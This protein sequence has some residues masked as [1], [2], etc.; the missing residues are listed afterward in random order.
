MV[1]DISNSSKNLLL[2]LALRIWNQYQIQNIMGSVKALK[3]RKLSEFH[4]EP[5]YPNIFTKLVLGFHQQKINTQQYLSENS[6]LFRCPLC[7]DKCENEI[8]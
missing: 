6:T 1:L 2:K 4:A 8:H 5:A 3:R 7:N